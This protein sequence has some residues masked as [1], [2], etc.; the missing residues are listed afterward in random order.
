[1]LLLAE[2]QCLLLLLRQHRRPCIMLHSSR[3]PWPPLNLLR[4]FAAALRLLLQ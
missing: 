4:A 1:L 3:Q 2:G